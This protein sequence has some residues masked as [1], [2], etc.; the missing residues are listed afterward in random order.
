[1]AVLETSAAKAK[2]THPPRTAIRTAG[3]GLWRYMG[4]SD[5]G[6]QLILTH[7]LRRRR[8]EPDF[9]AIVIADDTGA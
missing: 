6:A 5:C 8:A 4:G 3:P 1:M 2:R 9:A 7:A